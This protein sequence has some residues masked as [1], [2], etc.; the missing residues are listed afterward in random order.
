MG[1]F[2]ALVAAGALTFQDGLVCVRE[3]GRLMK[4]A[5]EENPGGMTAVLGLELQTV[6]EI[7]Q[8]TSH[9]SGHSVW[10]ANDNCPGQ[11]VISGE[12]AGLTEAEGELS[13]AGAR[14]VVR[15][16][17]SIPS[18]CPL[19]SEAQEKFNKVLNATPIVNPEIPIVGNV[20]ASLMRTADEIKADLGSQLISRVRWSQSMQTLIV[21]G[22]NRCF[23]IGS[24]KV[25]SGLMRRI[26]RSV[27]TTPLDSPTS[28]SLFSDRASETG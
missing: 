17:V 10:V 1:E 21:N 18:H 25:L 5:G 12:I 11:I 27:P 20:G 7:C 4:E 8:K 13:S 28:L 3:R 9:Q 2:A 19:M 6:E 15:L 23:E 24:G 14:K 26:D 22:V 16:A